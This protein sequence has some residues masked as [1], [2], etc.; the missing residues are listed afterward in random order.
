MAP[1]C[2]VLSGQNG[3]GEKRETQVATGLQSAANGWRAILNKPQNIKKKKK[4]G[5]P[6]IVIPLACEA[7]DTKYNWIT[8]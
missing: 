7:T 3:W 1:W 2:G 8:L 6:G 5:H 4:K